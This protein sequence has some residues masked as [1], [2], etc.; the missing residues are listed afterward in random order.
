[1]WGRKNPMISN[2]SGSALLLTLVAILLLSLLGLFIAIDANTG[3]KISD[4]YETQ[5]Q[6]TYAALAGLNHARALIR[7]IPI[8]D[9]LKGPDGV[10]NNTPAYLIQARKFDFRNALPLATLYG[11]DVSSPIISTTGIFDDGIISTGFYNGV[12]GTALI[13]LAGIGLQAANPYGAGMLVTARYFVK[14]TDN[15]GEASELSGDSSDNPFLDGDGVVISRSI[16][17]SRTFSETVGPVARLNSIAVFEAR[18]KRILAFDVGPALV[19]LGSKVNASFSGTYEIWG[20]KFAGVGTI[21]TDLA[22]SSMPDATIASAAGLSGNITGGGWPAPSVQDI[23]AAVFSSNS[24][25]PLMNPQFLWDFVYTRAPRFAD[26]FFSGNQHWSGGAAPYGGAYDIAKP[27]NAPGQDPKVTVVHG[28]LTIDGNY[29]GG[30]LLI[31]TGA[32]SYSGHFAFNGLVLAMG[33]GVVNA[34]GLG[35]GIQ[36]GLIAAA[37]AGKTSFG[38]PTIS[39]G[40]AS[41]IFSNGDAVKTAASLIPVSQISFREITGLDP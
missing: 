33:S 37:L 18:F 21:D 40:A 4:N 10:Y 6:A 13:P 35:P 31:V 28:D 36:G 29:S 41:K 24:K 1:M 19:V 8:D 23:S 30:G 5:V 2:E 25:S 22:D 15:N 32:L 3:V 20:D 39:I 34:D 27:W 9:L 16:G 38:S 11:L 14:V 12:D 17:V 7:G 26:F